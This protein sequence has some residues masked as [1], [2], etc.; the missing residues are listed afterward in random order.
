MAL[1]N[2][3]CDGDVTDQSGQIFFEAARLAP[4]K[5]LG[6]LRLAR[7][8]QSQPLQH[9]L[10]GDPFGTPG[11]PDCD[12][13]L[14]AD[15]Q[16]AFLTSYAGDF[17]TTVFS[18]DPAQVRAALERMGIDAAAPAADELYGA[19]GAGGAGW[20]TCAIACRC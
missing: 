19:G 2:A 3:A 7:A 17:L 10:P 8:R 12:N 13:L 16:R 18:P 6:G 5:K 11:R 20:P 4:A 15:A 1:V 14:D 9:T